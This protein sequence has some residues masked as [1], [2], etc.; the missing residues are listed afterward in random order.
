MTSCT[1]A[2]DIPRSKRVLPLSGGRNF[3]DIGGY[4]TR[5]GRLVRWGRVYRSGVMS[6]FTPE[7]LAHLDTLGIHTVCDFRTAAERRREP[8]RWNTTPP[9]CLNW[10]YDHRDVSL[11]HY[12]STSEPLTEQLARNC[13]VSLYR[14][15]PT[16]LDK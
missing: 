8:T 12:M 1:T 2:Q 10:E 9:Q 15:L 4:T 16:T 5:D 13:M 3:R 7:D 14:K 6:Y 11:R